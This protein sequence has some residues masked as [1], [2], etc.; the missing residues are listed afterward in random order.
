MAYDYVRSRPN[1]DAPLD[2]L[3][4]GFFEDLPSQLSSG[5]YDP[6]TGQRVD[7]GL[8]TDDRL[9]AIGAAQTARDRIRQA[10]RLT[11][12]GDLDGARD[13]YRDVLSERFG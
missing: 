12:E 7:A 1:T 10:R 3:V 9:D 6:A 4:D 2:T 8:S 11:R 13:A 5:V